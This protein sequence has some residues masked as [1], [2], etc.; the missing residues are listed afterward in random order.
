MLRNRSVLSL[1]LLAEACFR[2]MGTRDGGKTYFFW[3]LTEQFADL[4]FEKEHPPAVEHYVRSLNSARG[5]CKTFI[6]GAWKGYADSA[7]AV[8]D[9]AGGARERNFVK[10]AQDLI[11]YAGKRNDAM[12]GITSR[13]QVKALVRNLELDGYELRDARLVAIDEHAFSVEEIEP[14][15]I[16]LCRDVGIPTAQIEKELKECEDQYVAEKWGASIASARH[17]LEHVLQEAARH[18]LPTRQVS[19]SDGD[20]RRAAHVRDELKRT[21]FMD[22]KEHRFIGALYGLLSDQGGHPNMAERQ[23]ALICR[24]YALSATQ[25]VLLRLKSGIVA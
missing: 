17:L 12:A 22:E 23:N 25:F 16:R 9:P 13:L 7:F 6:L 11:D 1:A 18:W 4:L 3:D 14:L 5:A 10:L 15:L 20:L 21:G 19:P 24:Q 8:E 2:Q